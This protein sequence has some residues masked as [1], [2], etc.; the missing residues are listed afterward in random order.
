VKGFRDLGRD[1]GHGT[2]PF[3][4]GLFAGAGGHWASVRFTPPVA[5]LAALL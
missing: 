5:R 1:F 2:S 4:N 3:D